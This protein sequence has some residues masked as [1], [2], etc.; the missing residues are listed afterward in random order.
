[1]VGP[2]FVIPERKSN[3]PRVLKASSTSAVDGSSPWYVLSDG[4]R[5]KNQPFR[6]S[7]GLPSL[8]P[9]TK[10]SMW[11]RSSKPLGLGPRSLPV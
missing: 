8:E 3:V 9:C 5:R 4:E 7:T 1:M 10:D 2:G 6:G 11:L